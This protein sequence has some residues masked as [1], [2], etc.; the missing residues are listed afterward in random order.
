MIL[1]CDLIKIL[2]GTENEINPAIAAIAQKQDY[3]SQDWPIGNIDNLVQ[4]TD[5]REIQWDLFQNSPQNE[6][7]GQV[8]EQ[9]DFED[10]PLSNDF[11]EDEMF[12][13]FDDF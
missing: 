13:G 7:Y 2:N 5:F 8:L 10:Y 11:M 12:T 9:T 6:H 1:L 4:N 3:V